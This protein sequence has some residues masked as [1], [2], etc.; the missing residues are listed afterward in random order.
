ME[1]TLFLFGEALIDDVVLRRY[2]LRHLSAAGRRP[3]RRFESERPE[4]AFLSELDASRTRGEV[5]IFCTEEQVSLVTRELCSFFD[6]VI[7]THDERI[8][9]SKAKPVRTGYYRLDNLHVLTIYPGYDLPALEVDAAQNDTARTLHFFDC[10]PDALASALKTASATY[11]VTYRLCE[12]VGGWFRCRLDGGRF[13]DV[14]GM[15]RHLQT[16]FPACVAADDFAAWLI[17]ALEAEQKTI[18]FAESCTGGLLS[19]YLTAKSGSSAVFEGALVTYSN[20]LKSAWIAVEESTLE[21]HGAVSAETVEEMSLGALEV[22]GAD[23]AV[24]VSGI[25]GPTGAVPGKPV[26]TVYVAVRSKNAV[27]VER[28]QLHGDRNYIQ[29]QTVLAALKMLLMLDRKTFFK[30]S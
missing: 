3:R 6:D 15:H 22:A 25:A 23:Y 4:H 16:L 21:T 26:G 27:N 9:P 19:S 13:G 7:T 12:P 11:R 30:I 29:E 20:R 28:L 8:V 24:A 18:T 10:D 17:A 14:E 2:V 1:T 5:F